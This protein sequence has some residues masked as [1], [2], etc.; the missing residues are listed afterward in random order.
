LDECKPLAPGARLF[1]L[2]ADGRVDRDDVAAVTPS[3]HVHLSLTPR[4]YAR[5]GVTGRA[6]GVGSEK[7]THA[8]T[9]TISLTNTP[10]RTQA[11]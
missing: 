5:M 10:T 2:C 8:H 6:S 4:T 11:Q 9:H 3:G 1:A 7:H